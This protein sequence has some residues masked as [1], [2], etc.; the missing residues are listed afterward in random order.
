MITKDELKN[1]I[2]HEAGS[3]LLQVLGFIVYYIGLIILGVLLF[4]LA[5]FVTINI[6]S[7][8]SGLTRIDL[9]L[10]FFGGLAFLA[11]WWFCIQLAWYLI[12]PL[13]YVHHASDENRIEVK[14]DECPGL[15]ALVDEI[16]T[17][18]NNKRPKHIYL[19]AEVNACVF[20]NST[21]LWSIFFPTRKN[22]MLGVGLLY[23]L[24]REE[25]KAVLSHEFGHFAQGSMRVG[26]ITYRLM[27]IISKMIEHAREEARNAD[28][29]DGYGRWFHIAS[30]VMGWITYMTISFYNKIERKNRSLS[31]YME[32]EADAVACK[33]VGSEAF[34]SAMCKIETMS[35]RL[36]RYENI[37]AGFLRD[38]KRLEE[39]WKGYEF[40][41]NIWN[42]DEGKGFNY[43]AE[44]TQPIEDDA[45]YPSKIHVSNG[46]NTHPPLEERLNMARSYACES[47]GVAVD[48][49]FE[50]VPITTQEKVGQQCQQFIAENMSE[51]VEWEKLEKA[52]FDSFSGWLKESRKNYVP[53]FLAPFV[54]DITLYVDIDDKE[55]VVPSP[56]TEENRNLLLEYKQAIADY[57]TLQQVSTSG[58]G[59]DFTY[60]GVAPENYTET[61]KK[62]EE[63]LNSLHKKVV[64][65]DKAIYYYLKIFSIDKQ[66]LNLMVWMLQL[67]S[68]ALNELEA[69]VNIA[70]QISQAAQYYNS[71]NKEFSLRDD[72]R[73][74]LAAKFRKVTQKMPYDSIGRVCSGWKRDDVAIEE[75]IKQWR[76]FSED[77]N[78]E[79]V[80]ISHLMDMIYNLYNL[81]AQCRNIAQN[82]LAHQIINAYYGIEDEDSEQEQQPATG[83]NPNSIESNN[84]QNVKAT[85]DIWDESLEEIPFEEQCRYKL[86]AKWVTLKKGDKLDPAEVFGWKD[87]MTNLDEYMSFF[88]FMNILNGPISFD[89]KT[90]FENALREENP[91]VATIK[92]IACTYIV[93]GDVVEQNIPESTMWFQK[94]AE[95]ND[96]E[97]LCRLAGAYYYGYG[98]EQDSHKA[99]TLWKQSIVEGGYPDA[100]LDLGLH[101]H[102]GEGVPRNNDHFFALMIRAAKQGQMMAQYNVGYAYDHGHGVE[103]NAEK[104]LYWLQLSAEQGYEQAQR[105]LRQR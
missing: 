104:A 1:S 75:D 24:S 33:I 73:I 100:L 102:R 93:G 49:S 64:E 88:S 27:M 37:I 34:V 46:W 60:E 14:K 11:M 82:K 105:Y 54:G 56:F 90:D 66:E 101:Y 77:S 68:N 98:V 6:P 3:V 71:V 55:M 25:L 42:N 15:F 81:M 8:L 22:L 79:G 78:Y 103:K 41:W 53:Y 9:R 36:N 74:D 84:D 47:P 51:P 39:Y 43:R 63:Y 4:G 87:C 31:R 58:D 99:I 94:A 10:V 28:E 32:F 7:L 16:A 17:A 23:G 76:S 20:Y 89:N 26:S 61:I 92:K 52:S 59:F 62:H 35:N 48:D 91:N 86:Y 38:G 18:T 72:V 85:E 67:S 21:S 57:N 65:I 97:A 50:L 96:P 80:S 45:K 44:L 5:F 19:N 30:S 83:N 2:R 12:K 13:F 40:N 29:S 70:R 95:E 69:V